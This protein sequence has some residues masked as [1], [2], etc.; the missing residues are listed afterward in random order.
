MNVYLKIY[1]FCDADMYAIHGAGISVSG[2]MKLVL[3]YK[4]RGKDLHILIPTCLTYDLAGKKRSIPLQLT[5]TDP[6]SIRFLQKALKKRQRT[7]YLK[8]VLRESLLFQMTGVFLRD[9]DV[10]RRENARIGGSIAD[11]AGI[12]DLLVCMPGD[13]RHSYLPMVK[14][15]TMDLSDMPNAAEEEVSRKKKHRSAPADISDLYPDR[16]LLDKV[17]KK[18]EKNAN[19]K[20]PEPDAVPVKKPEPEPGKEEQTREPEPELKPVSEDAGEKGTDTGKEPEMPEP[21]PDTGY[22]EE[23]MTAQEA[24]EDYFTQFEDL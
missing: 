5:I 12:D 11:H 19:E 15:R 9:G 16:E 3:A 18:K 4:A 6:V 17:K 13:F 20:H 2:L 8:A 21:V 24:E 1:K 7:A 22:E 23:E 14:N 10:L